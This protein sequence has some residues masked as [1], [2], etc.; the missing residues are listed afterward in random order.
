MWQHFTPSDHLIDPSTSNIIDIYLLTRG[1]YSNVQSYVR[2][3]TSVEPVPESSL[4]LRNAYRSLL[5][6]KM[7]SDTVILHSARVKFLFGSKAIPEL[8]SKFKIVMASGAKLTSDQVRSRVLSI[9]NDYFR[10]E[11]WDFGQEF[12]ATELC[13]V[14]HKNLPVDI[15]SVVMVPEFPANYFGDLYYIRSAPEEIFVSCATLDNIEIVSSLDK[16][17]LKQKS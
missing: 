16:T 9:I 14:I 4:E 12:Y 13:T 10:I 15:A 7:I 1:Y 2:D 5:E 8:R 6:N 17:V 3:L 11:N